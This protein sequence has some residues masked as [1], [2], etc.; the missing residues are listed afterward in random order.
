MLNENKAGGH[1]IPYFK[2]HYKDTVIKILCYWH[3]ERHIEQ[4]NRIKTQK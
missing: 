4:W 2:T 1:K 3:K